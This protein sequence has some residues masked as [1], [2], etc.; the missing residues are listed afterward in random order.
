MT[1][2]SRG[3]T[4]ILVAGEQ[5]KMFVIDL[6]KGEIIKQIPTEHHYKIMRR[7]R[8]ICAA[9]TGSNVHV[10][11]PV[12]FK[13]SK[14]WF[15][16]AAA[17]HDMDAQHDFIVTCGLSPRQQG[18]SMFD[19]LVKVFDLK[20]MEAMPPIPFPAGAAYVRM[21]PSMSTTSIVV[22]QQGQMHVVDLMNP[23]TSN[24]RQAKSLAYMSM[25]EIAP[26]GQ[27]VALADSEC[28]IHLWGSPN[29]IRFA[30]VATPVE[31][32]THE[33]PV[34]HVDWKDDT[35]LSSV[36]MPYYR[37]VLLSAWP[38]DAIYEIGAPPVKEDPQFLAS[39]QRRD[40]GFYGKNTRKQRRN[41]VEDTRSLDKEQNSL[42][43]PRFLSEKAHTPA[44]TPAPEEVV[45]ESV[46]SVAPRP[47][48][49]H[50]VDVPE[51][52]QNIEI[53]YSKYGIDDFDFG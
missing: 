49:S 18:Y 32:P 30:E 41:Q 45:P 2:T 7:S 35:P 12:T 19:P 1:F 11:D 43:A 6:N 39:A 17:I 9:T 23:N 26:S 50:N 3:T 53:M 46:K 40:W 8:H 29:K 13:V 47:L 4:E 16:H 42:K 48:E 25:I 31:F 27:A 14:T 34:P 28:N 44:G 24:V 33:D 5:D 37:E 22:S 10:L 52:Y 21:H 36:G 20:N 15:A 51:L 38:R